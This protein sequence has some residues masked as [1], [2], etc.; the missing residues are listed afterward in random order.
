MSK[1]RNIELAKRQAASSF[2]ND[3]GS[4]P[5]GLA[6]RR[7]VKPLPKPLTPRERFARLRGMYFN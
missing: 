3:Y 2:P 6:S 4:Y 1:A 7:T 5:K